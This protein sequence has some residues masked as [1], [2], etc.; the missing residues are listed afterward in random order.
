MKTPTKLLGFKVENVL[1]VKLAE[2]RFDG[3]T[4]KIGGANASGKSSA[5]KALCL[6][7]FGVDKKEVPDP[8]R[9]GAKDGDVT[10]WFDTGLTVRRTF[11]PGG[12]GGLLV[13][14]ETGKLDSPQTVLNSFIGAMPDPMAFANGDE[15]EQADTLRKMAGI[16]TSALDAKRAALYSERTDLGRKA[17]DVRTLADKAEKFAGV[18]P[19][20]IDPAPARAALSEVSGKR[21]ALQSKLREID[22]GESTEIAA[23]RIQFEDANGALKAI[24]DARLSAVSR[25]ASNREE[26]ALLIRGA[27]ELDAQANTLLLK[28][29]PAKAAVETIRAKKPAVIAAASDSR[30]AVNT[31]LS[32]VTIEAAQAEVDRIADHNAKAGQNMEAARL[33]ADAKK[34]EKLHADADRAIAAVDEEKRRI[35]AEAKYP[36]PGI[37]VTEDGYVTLDGVRIKQANDGREIEIGVDLALSGDKPIK[38]ICIRNASLLDESAKDRITA[39]ADKVPG[40]IVFMELVGDGQGCSFVMEDG[41]VAGQ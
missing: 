3:S 4:V 15:K 26:A 37:A 25:A 32:T 29:E 24:E 38:I 18:D 9:K 10:A 17:K 28:S 34:A 31:E 19:V 36:I 33:E 11:T 30:A 6:A 41:E 1:G 27:G 7:L 8:L 5:I 14:D 21:D 13:K 20:K 40:S 23:L 22:N 16:D 39:R 12:G 2:I 35:L